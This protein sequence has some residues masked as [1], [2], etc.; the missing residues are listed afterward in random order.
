MAQR[1]KSGRGSGG[2]TRFVVSEDKRP[3]V[4]LRPGMK[5]EVT[6]VMLVDPQL[7]RPKN[8]GARL[9]G[10]SGTCLALVELGQDVINPV[11]QRGRG[12]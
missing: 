11:K 9:C 1:K 8:I 7:K 4:T 3:A 12:A 2:S 5:L 10:G 6:S